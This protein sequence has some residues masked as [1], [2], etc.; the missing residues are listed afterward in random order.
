M[1]T[2]INALQKTHIFFQMAVFM[3]LSPVVGV[4]MRSKFDSSL[5]GFPEKK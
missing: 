3:I 4:M 5:D 1:H 2:S